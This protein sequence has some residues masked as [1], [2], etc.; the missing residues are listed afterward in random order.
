M[1]RFVVIA[2]LGIACGKNG[3]TPTPGSASATVT[4]PDP[5]GSAGPATGGSAD[6]NGGADSAKVETELAALEQLKMKTCACADLACIE[7][8]GLEHQAW[9][10]KA[11]TALAGVK[12]SKAQEE[13]GNR[14]D[15]EMKACYRWVEAGLGSGAGGS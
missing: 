10:A 1:R 14:L 7:K 8:V 2:I 4:E 9:K 15:D 3:A 11:K 6:P 12:S 13:R 5:V